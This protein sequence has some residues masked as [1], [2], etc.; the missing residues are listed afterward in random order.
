MNWLSKMPNTRT[1]KIGVGN[2]M[3][4][5]EINEK[6]RFKSRGQR[7]IRW[8]HRT[9]R[10]TQSHCRTRRV[11]EVNTAGKARLKRKR[12]QNYFR[13]WYRQKKNSAQIRE[14]RLQR[15][16]CCESRCNQ[17]SHCQ[18]SQ[19]SHSTQLLEIIY[20]RFGSYM[21]MGSLSSHPSLSTPGCKSG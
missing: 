18:R 4:E 5:S 21:F 12:G 17:H 19:H 7:A 11:S 13:K 8:N 1:N 9:V 20:I 14:Q 10:M 15:R 6:W 2:R 16:P 3:P